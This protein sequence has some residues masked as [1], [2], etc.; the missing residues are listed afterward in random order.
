MTLIMGL[1]V[2]GQARARRPGARATFRHANFQRVDLLWKC[3]SQKPKTTR[4]RTANTGSFMERMSAFID[5]IS[6]LYF[7]WY[8]DRNLRREAISASSATP[9]TITASCACSLQSTQF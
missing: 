4:G 2:T 6:N 1:G 7:R 9:P 8:V 3:F 5:D